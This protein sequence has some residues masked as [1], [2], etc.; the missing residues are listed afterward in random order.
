[1]ALI[2]RWRYMTSSSKSLVKNTAISVVV[3]L[4]GLTVLR[5]LFPWLM[6]GLAVYGAYCL[7]NRPST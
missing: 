4:M 5:A 2:P 6:L 3:I 7:L 1:M